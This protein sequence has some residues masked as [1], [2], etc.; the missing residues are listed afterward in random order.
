MT[1]SPIAPSARCRSR[2]TSRT[3][4]VPCD[5]GNEPVDVRPADRIGHVTAVDENPAPLVELDRVLDREL[6]ELV[7]QVERQS[8]TARKPGERAVHRP[9]IE[10]A[11][12]EPLGELPCDRALAGPCGPIDC[13]DH[14]EVAPRSES[15]RSKKPGKL[16]AADSAPCTVDALAGDEP[17]HRAEHRDP[18]VASRVDRAAA[19]PCRHAAHLEAVRRRPDVRAERPQRVDDRLDPVCLLRPQLGRAA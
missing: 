15:R 1:T 4:V 19:Q 8:A 7:G 5:H 13:D 3:G 14:Q 9:G 17:G 6:G 11:E 16:T 12:A 10:V 2:I 18:V